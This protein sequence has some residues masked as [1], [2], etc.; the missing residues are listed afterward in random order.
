M[1]FIDRLLIKYSESDFVQKIKSKI[2]LIVILVLS[3]LFISM[4]INAILSSGANKTTTLIILGSGLVIILISFIFLIKGKY[5]ISAIIASLIGLLISWSMIILTNGEPTLARLDSIIFVFGSL[6]I[7]ALLLN[8]FYLLGIGIFNVIVLILVSWLIIYKQ[9][10]ITGYELHDYIIDNSIVFISSTALI[11]LSSYLNEQALKRS[12][13]QQQ[14]I[15]KQF[16]DLKSIIKVIKNSASD[17]LTTSVEVADKA[18]KLSARSINKSS[19]IEEIASTMEEMTATVNSNYDN[20]QLTDSKATDSAKSAENS[21]VIIQTALSSV[22]QITEKIKV[23]QDISSQTNMLSLNAAIEAARAGEYG[24]GFSVVA[25]EVR[26]LAE[27]S[28]NA[29]KEINLISEESTLQ[30]KNAGEILTTVVYQIKE[31]AELVKEMRSATNEQKNGI[32]QISTSIEQLNIG[33]S[34]D[35]ELSESLITM[36]EKLKVISEKFS[37]QVT[38]FDTE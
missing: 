17:L 10:G 15:A 5:N 34:E 35:S 21:N 38:E 25:S 8:K 28:Q 9:M 18:T 27:K 4:F 2:L 26:K 23:I 32:S 24:K 1:K 19:S 37:A 12:V 31:T 13:T 6:L 29:A 16:G 30:S 22:L 3:L 14:Q 7:A 11:M 20:T 36:A 33:S